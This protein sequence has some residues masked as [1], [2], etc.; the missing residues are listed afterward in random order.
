LITVIIAHHLNEN[1]HILDWCLES[2]LLQN[3]DKEIIVLSDAKMPPNVPKGVTLFH[4]TDGTLYTPGRKL[5]VGL[6]TASPKTTH[7]VYLNDDIILGKDCLKSL[8]ESAGT[9]RMITPL[10][11]AD[12]L[13]ILYQD[14]RFP[15]EN[16]L[17]YWMVNA[18]VVRDVIHNHKPGLTTVVATHRL[19][20]S[21]FIM[22]KEVY[23][24]VGEFDEKFEV[25]WED[26]D[27]CVRA[28]LAGVKMGVNTGAF[29]FHIG[30]ATISK[31]K[32]KQ[33]DKRN[34]E[35][36]ISKWGF[37]Y[38][39]KS[40]DVGFSLMAAAGFGYLHKNKVME[41]ETKE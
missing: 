27:Y 37:F 32:D 39:P 24:K 35:Y 38:L 10:C 2:V 6:R 15:K 36:F 13:N 11:N 34:H 18:P 19:Y 17:T 4:A 12:D 20:M 1:Q 3:E 7:F 41:F 25:G 33:R 40:T 31:T 28:S 29:S 21:C 30:S 22:P 26:E 5:N 23:E 14:K 8:K 16:E 9:E